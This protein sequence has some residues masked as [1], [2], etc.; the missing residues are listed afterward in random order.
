MRCSNSSCRASSSMMLLGG[1]RK[2]HHFRLLSRNGW[3]RGMG[4]RFL[5]WLLFSYRW[6]PSQMSRT[7]RKFCLIN[8]GEYYPTCLLTCATSFVSCIRILRSNSF[9]PL[10]LCTC[11]PTYTYLLSPPFFSVCLSSHSQV[12]IVRAGEGPLCTYPRSRLSLASPSP[13]IVASSTPFYVALVFSRYIVVSS[14]SFLS[15]SR[16]QMSNLSRYP[17]CIN[18]TF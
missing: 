11:P 16:Y 13:V 15:S 17:I 7:E 6:S 12:S 8:V 3:R 5:L 18:T 10:K 1:R 9:S 2:W 4:C 14:I